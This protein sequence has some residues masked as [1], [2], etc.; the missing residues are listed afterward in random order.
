MERGEVW[1]ALLD[2]RRA[3]VLLSGDEASGFRAMEI[4]APATVDERRGFVLLH[5]DD[6]TL[7]TVASV[8]PDVRGVGV[9]IA[10]GEGEGLQPSGV[11]RVALPRAGDPVPC[12]WLVTLTRDYLIERAGVMPA[13]KLDQLDRVLRLAGI[14]V[15][16]G[17]G[18]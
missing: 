9:E 10:V 4:V 15:D 7:E 17:R 11:V 1:W 2:E 14:E 18:W 6:A 8:G 12:T 5:A 13:A 16:G 3:V